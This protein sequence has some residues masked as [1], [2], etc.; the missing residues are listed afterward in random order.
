MSDN[1]ACFCLYFQLK[2]ISLRKNEVVVPLKLDCAN[3]PRVL[4]VIL[5]KD[6]AVIFQEFAGSLSSILFDDFV[7]SIYSGHTILYILF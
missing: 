2:A 3:I 6:E 7:Y 4:G 1:L 5:D